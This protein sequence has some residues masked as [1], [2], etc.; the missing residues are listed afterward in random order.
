M[1]FGYPQFPLW[2]LIAL[3]KIC[4]FHSLEPCKN[5]FVLVGKFLKKLEYLGPDSRCAECMRSKE[6]PPLNDVQVSKKHEVGESAN[7]QNCIY[8]V[9]INTVVHKLYSV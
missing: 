1:W 6:A 3:A 2:I 7:L 4:F 8:Y 9:Y 5:T